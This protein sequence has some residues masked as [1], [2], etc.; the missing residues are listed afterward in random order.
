MENLLVAVQLEMS[1]VD[2]R[3]VYLTLLAL[4][5]LKEGFDSKKD[6]WQLLAK[7]AKDF[8][9]QCGVK[10]A[11]VLIKKFSLQINA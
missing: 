7:K 11:D 1:E 9:K 3:C 5:I 6:E 8:L 4:Y 2:P 10:R